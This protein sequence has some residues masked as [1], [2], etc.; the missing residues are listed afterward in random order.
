MSDTIPRTPEGKVAFV[1]GMLRSGHITREE[2]IDLLTCIPVDPLDLCNFEIGSR[3]EYL[4]EPRKWWKPR[5]WF[6]R[7]IISRITYIDR[8]E[9][10]ISCEP[11]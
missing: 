6:R 11:E 1:M 3:V 10:I 7:P 9:G 8:S 2:A 5:T 4:P